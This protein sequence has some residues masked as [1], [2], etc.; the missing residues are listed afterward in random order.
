MQFLWLFLFDKNY[1]VS[2]TDSNPCY[3]L[4]KTQ[5]CYD[6]ERLHKHYQELI[7]PQWLAKHWGYQNFL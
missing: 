7:I 6:F 4:D 3:Y 1:I 2:W 5:T